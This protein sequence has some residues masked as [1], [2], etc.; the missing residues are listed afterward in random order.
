MSNLK[1]DFVILFLICV[2]AF[3]F[4]PCFLLGKLPFDFDNLAFYCPL[5]SLSK[6]NPLPFWEP[7][8]FSGFPVYAD[9]QY[10]IFYPLRL[11]FTFCDIYLA[12]PLFYLIHYWIT[13]IGMYFFFRTLKFNRVSSLL[14]S[15]C[16]IHSSYLIGKIMCSA[17]V[18]FATSLIPYIL[19][20]YFKLLEKESL[21]YLLGSSTI[22]GLQIFLGSPH[23][24]F[25]TCLTLFL[26]TLV[27]FALNKNNNIKRDIKYFFFF[28]MVLIG[29]VG[30]SAVQI[31]PS[32]ELFKHSIRSHLTFSQLTEKCLPFNWLHTI[33]LGGTRTPEDLDITSYIGIIAIPFELIGLLALKKDN[34]PSFWFCVLLIFFSIFISLGKYGGIYYLFY[35]FLFANFLTFPTRSLILLVLARTIL[36]S[37]GVNWILTYNYTNKFRYNFSKS[38]L[39]FTLLLFLFWIFVFLYYGKAYFYCLANPKWVDAKTFLLINLSFFLFLAILLIYLFVTQKISFFIFTSLLLVLLLFDLKQ[40]STRLHIRFVNPKE[41]LNKPSTVS[42]LRT[43]YKKYEKD[44]FRVIGYEPTRMYAIDQ[45]DNRFVDYIAPRLGELYKLEDAHGYDPLM[46]TNYVTLMEKMA[47]RAETDDIQRMATVKNPYSRFLDLLNVRYIIGEVNEQSIMRKQIILRPYSVLTIELN[48][49]EKCTGIGI[50]SLLDNA[51]EA[52]QEEKIAEVI[53]IGSQQEKFFS[54]IRAG[55]E[56]ADWRSGN[57]EFYSMHTAVMKPAMTYERFILGKDILVNNYYTRINFND[58]FVPKQIV[59]KSVHPKA[60]LVIQLISIIKENDDTRFKKIFEKTYDEVIYENLLAYKRAF[61]VKKL[62]IVENENKNLELLS[63][64]TIKLNETALITKETEEKFNLAS[65][66]K[67]SDFYDSSCLQEIIFIKYSSHRI[68]LQ[69]NCSVPTVLVLSQPYYP[70]WKAFI[71]GLKKDVFRVN[72]ALTG[73]KI[74]KGLH[75]VIFLFS[76]LSLKIG[77]AVSFLT[78]VV[79]LALLLNIMIKVTNHKI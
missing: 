3:L 14:G 31:I 38:L 9:P 77:S 51:L 62:M 13:G 58:S 56:S 4:F 45:H 16:F 21:V 43:L 55:V 19:T 46:L 50:I 42:F 78:L 54:L 35:Y 5:F 18:F 76:P 17:T 11:I 59:F 41:F 7:Y 30:I 34:S 72:Y 48:I 33:F 10:A 40:F 12:M 26:L 6:D 39:M 64:S 67:V 22:L 8:Q 74:P 70:G 60:I 65:F 79:F 27:K 36:V 15:Y 73:L 25:Y 47:G 71:D 52:I 49:N 32:M 75:H 44:P 66:I 63:E 20:F 2:S 69:T 1:K 28:L 37:A 61:I 29:G 57:S 53:I 23:Q 24:T 68:E